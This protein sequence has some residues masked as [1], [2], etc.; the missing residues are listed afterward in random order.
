MVLIYFYIYYGA[1]GIHKQLF[2]RMTIMLFILHLLK[3]RGH[4]YHKDE[5]SYMSVLNLLK[6]IS[7]RLA[8]NNQHSFWENVP[9]QKKIIEGFGEPADDIER[10]FFQYR[11]QKI[12]SFSGISFLVNFCSFFLFLYFL[13]FRRSDKIE[14]KRVDGYFTD[15]RNESRIPESIRCGY[16]QLIIGDLGKEYL[17]RTDKKLILKLVE[18][19]PFEWQFHLKCLIKLRGYSYII[20]SYSP[21]AIITCNEYSFTSS[22]LTYYCELNGVKHIDVM[23]GDK[24]YY[25]RDSFFHYHIMYVWH[26]HFIHLF[27][28]LRAHCDEYI[29]EI[30]KCF[31]INQNGVIPQNDFTYYLQIADREELI[32]LESALRVLKENNMVISIRP[33]PIVSKISDI[34]EIFADYNIENNDAV[35][36]EESIRNTNAVISINS[37]VIFQ[38]YCNNKRIVIDD[39]SEPKLFSALEDMMYMGVNIDHVL[40]SRVRDNALRV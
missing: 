23:H 27:E 33:H 29:V 36:I 9:L 12:I 1:A 15:K 20:N 5:K 37:T 7:K 4:Y 17:S 26:E 31:Y 35:S 10:S 22:F 38:A 21:K 18:R 28:K 6:T 13:Y 8:Y 24:V 34:N 25:I 16:E 40:L 32:K 11:C 39:V 30:P 3:E 14:G 19:Y 2:I